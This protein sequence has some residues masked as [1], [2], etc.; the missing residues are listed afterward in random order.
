MGAGALSCQGVATVSNLATT[1]NFLDVMEH[2]PWP[3]PKPISYRLYHDDQGQP[4]FYSM[5]DLPGTYIEVDQSIYVTSPGNV[6][7][8]D[9]KLIVIPPGI[10]V[11]KLRP[12]ATQ[13]IVCDKRDICVVVDS[14]VPHQR[15]RQQ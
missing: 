8:A 15:W 11:T 14:D 12:D 5:E 9:G 3:E 13:G 10:S 2:F 1:Q 6:K 7:V 4:L